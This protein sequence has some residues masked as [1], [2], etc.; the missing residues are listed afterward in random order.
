MTASFFTTSWDDGHPLDLRV[1]DLLAKHGF[2]GTFYVPA[3]I[4]SG[5]A[6]NPKGLPVISGD[7]L[8]ELD[9]TFEVGSHTL[10][11]CDLVS[12]DI[13]EARRQVVGGKEW[14]ESELGHGVR[15][16]CYPGGRYSAPV[17]SMVRD[18][19]FSYARTTDDLFG[20]VR[21]DPFRMPVSFHLYPRPR[22]E[23]VRRF[24]K[25]GAWNKRTGTAM[26]A[27]RGNDDLLSTLQ[28]VVDHVFRNGG[29]FHLWGHSWELEK[30]GGWRLLDSFLRFAA[31][32]VPKESRVTNG[33]LA[34]FATSGTGKVGAGAATLIALAML[35]D[36]A[37]VAKSQ[38]FGAGEFVPSA[39]WIE[40]EVERKRRARER[41]LNAGNVH[42]RRSTT[43]PLRTLRAM[44]HG[45]T[46]SSSLRDSRI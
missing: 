45:F 14:L 12:V 46:W 19:G 8:R 22:S 13:D 38:A 2:T 4:P 18:A 34:Q 11:H 41:P 27:L 21:S 37:P 16:F 15:G 24:V 6:C 44:H 10:E 9:R 3:Q 43:D 30:V 42:R 1:A 5:G 31:E 26:A 28:T 17:C 39:E 35:G 33:Q 7:S 36:P 29:M 25:G 23:L 20:R 40:N 32:R